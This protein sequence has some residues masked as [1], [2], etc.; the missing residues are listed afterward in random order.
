MSPSAICVHF[1]IRAKSPS[2][3][4]GTAE[5]GGSL[6]A[7]I[8]RDLRSGCAF[9]AVPSSQAA[10]IAALVR[11]VTLAFRGDRRRRQTGA[12][13]DSE[14]NPPRQ[15]NRARTRALGGLQVAD[16]GKTRSAYCQVAGH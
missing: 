8:R 13:I 7:H 3:A 11:R 12:G 5:Y 16:L 1:S 10:R 9:L 15:L 4:A 2:G 6:A 14:L